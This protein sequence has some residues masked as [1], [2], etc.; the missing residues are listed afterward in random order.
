MEK[1]KIAINGFGRVGRAAF[2]VALLK[3]DVEVVAINDLTDAKT[4]AHLLQY[5]SVYGR[6]AKSVESVDAAIVINGIHYPVL[7]EK[8][9]KNLPWGSLGVDVVLE[10]TG[11]FTDQK[12]AATHLAAGAKKVIISAPVR[13]DEVP[14]MVLGV[15]QGTYNQETIINNASC[16]TNCIAPV[17]KV[18]LQHWGIAKAMMSTTHSYTTDQNLQDG[19]N[20]DLRRA[21][22]A[23]L[24]IVPTTTGAAIAVT[25]TIP[26]LV[27]L[28]DGL[29]IRVPTPVVSLADFTFVL[30]KKTTVA[31]VNQVLEQEAAKKEWQ[32]IL[33]VTHD[34]V[35]SSDLIGDS[36][37]A[38]IDLALTQIVDGDLLKIIAWY[39][40][41]WGYANRLVEMAQVISRS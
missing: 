29:A 21:R 30:K 9:P 16:T 28:F 10:C 14:T 40:N 2:K 20:K 26:E 19:P 8:E 11:R 15:N 6:F 18:V 33:S 24:N 22:A 32:G 36:H 38:I 34:P 4:L 27:G 3:K 41:E 5:D 37:S 17:A 13:G 1:I 12:G 7:A 31:E 25:K 35:V 23:A 39:D